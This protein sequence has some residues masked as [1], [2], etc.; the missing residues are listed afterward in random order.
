MRIGSNKLDDSHWSWVDGTP[1][2]YSNW[3]SGKPDNG[4]NDEYCLHLNYG[5]NGRWN[6]IQCASVNER[7]IAYIC[8]KNDEGKLNT[9]ELINKTLNI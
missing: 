5:G 1:L 9:F 4:G 3:V 8:Q 7:T 6:D 2:D